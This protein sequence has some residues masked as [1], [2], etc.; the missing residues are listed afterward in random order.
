MLASSVYAEFKWQHFGADPYAATRAEAMRTRESAFRKMD[1]PAQVVKQLMLATERPGEKVRIVVGNHLSVM[2][3]KGGVVHRDVVVAFVKPP[4]SGRMEYAAPAEKWQVL[5]EGK[6][7]TI[8]LPEICYNWSNVVAEDV[9]Q[10]LP[11]VAEE[12]QCLTVEY[13]IEPGDEVRF[14][15]LAQKRLPASACWRLCDGMDCAAPPSPCDMCDWAGPRSVIPTG[16]W[17]LHTGRYVARRESQSLRFPVE[18]ASE[19]VALCVTRRGAQSNS[20][21]VQ[22]TAWV[23]RTTVSIPYGGQEWPSWGMDKIDWSKWPRSHD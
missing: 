12:S 7:F 10:T 15:V 22:P 8:F 18:V 17:P 16:F 19:Y 6:V 21:I 1:L 11:T 13:V 20:W 2:L 3:S 5:W 4:I 23:D 9:A 14:A